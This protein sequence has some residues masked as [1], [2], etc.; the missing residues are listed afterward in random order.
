MRRPIKSIQ[1]HGWDPAVQGWFGPEELD[2]GSNG[3]SR[4]LR[5]LRNG[6]A[7]LYGRFA[8]AFPG[9][10]PVEMGTLVQDLGDSAVAIVDMEGARGAPPQVLLVVPQPRVG[11]TRPELAF[12]FVA[13]LRFFRVIDDGAELAVHDYIET[14]LRE[15]PPNASLVFSIGAATIAPEFE[16]TLARHVEELAVALVQ[17]TTAKLSDRRRPVLS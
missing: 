4:L 6:G 11:H 9:E 12:E 8:R 15:P 7:S 14:A 3:G 13:C 16:V 2:P 17:W 5:K 1:L 10:V